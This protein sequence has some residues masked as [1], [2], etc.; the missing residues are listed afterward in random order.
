MSDQEVNP[1]EDPPLENLEESVSQLNLETKEV[2]LVKIYVGSL[3]PDLEEDGL[4][5]LLN[6]KDL[7]MP[8]SVLVKRGYAFLEFTDQDKA[9]ETISGIDGE[10]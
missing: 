6:E 9:D 5:F 7:P 1:A 3:P 2:N 10:F 4:R 8:E